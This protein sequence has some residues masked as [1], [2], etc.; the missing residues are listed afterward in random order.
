MCRARPS[1]RQ[2]VPPVF[3]VIQPQYTRPVSS[4]LPDEREVLRRQLL[5]SGADLRLVL[6]FRWSQDEFGR[7]HHRGEVNRYPSGGR[8]VATWPLAQAQR[9]PLIKREPR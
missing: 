6:W 8:A 9:G 2:S 4:D 1:R 3:F 5:R 7:F